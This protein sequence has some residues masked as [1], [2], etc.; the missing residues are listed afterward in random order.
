MEMVTL[1][2]D[3]ALDSIERG[4][5]ADAKTQIAILLW[6]RQRSHQ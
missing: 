2:L 4:D 5:I 6:A 1:A 3:E